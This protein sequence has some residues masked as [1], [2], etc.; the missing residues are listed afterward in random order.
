MRVAFHS[1][2]G[3]RCPAGDGYTAYAAPAHVSRV[4]LSAPRDERRAVEEDLPLRGRLGIGTERLREAGEPD[5]A[6]DSGRSNHR[7]CCSHL[8]ASFS[9]SIAGGGHPCHWATNVLP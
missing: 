1:P 4:L 9:L 7:H 5:R 2:T 3:L 6:A 8:S